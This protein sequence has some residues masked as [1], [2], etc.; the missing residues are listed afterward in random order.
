MRLSH[1]VLISIALAL[2]FVYPYIE[3]RYY[4]EVFGVRFTFGPLILT[5]VM[6]FLG[7]LTYGLTRSII[8]SFLYAFSLATAFLLV[9]GSNPLVF[10]VSY[11]PFYSGAVIAAFFVDVLVTRTISDPVIEGVKLKRPHWAPALIGAIGVL[12]VYL[13]TGN[14][15]LVV[16]SVIAL[17]FATLDGSWYFGLASLGSWMSLPAVVDSPYRPVKGG[18]CLGE[19]VGELRPAGVLAGGSNWRRLRGEFCLDFSRANNYNVVIVG[20]SGSGKSTLVK[21]ILKE[22]K[23]VDY[24]VIDPHGE[25]ADLGER[26]NATEVPLNPL[27]LFGASPHQRSVEI[28]SMVRSVFKLGP[29]Q[30]ITLANLLVETYAFKGITDDPKTW[31]IDPPTFADVLAILDREKKLASDSQALARL[32]SLEPYL[33][34]LN[35]TIFPGKGISLEELFKGRKVLDVSRVQTREV[36]YILIETVL[37]GALYRLS[38]KRGKLS[39]LI[40]IDEAPF[41]LEKESGLQVVTRLASEGRKFGL[42]LILISQYFEPVKQVIPNTG[43]QFVMR[44]VNPEDAKYASSMFSGGDERAAKA[45]LSTFGQ[46]ERGEAITRD[47]L[48]GRVVRVRFSPGGAS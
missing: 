27:S 39:N 23:D 38:E 20:T 29:L 26:I 17:F 7:F 5:A 28:A 2:A 41:V 21:S 47:L 16:G 19:I 3:S 37:R 25:H 42:G 40:V 35:E 4:F 36:S 46:L 8:I 31:S 9:Q 22:L 6:V 15:F 43:Y 14:A 1:A 33:K 11:A 18:I 13:V 44:L 24:L 45:L 30:E 34:F 48:S 32:S 12:V 10:L